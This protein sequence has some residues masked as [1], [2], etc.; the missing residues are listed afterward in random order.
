MRVR[1]EFS[2]VMAFIPVFVW[3]IYNFDENDQTNYQRRS[4]DMEQTERS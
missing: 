3:F 2:F 4:K 1:L